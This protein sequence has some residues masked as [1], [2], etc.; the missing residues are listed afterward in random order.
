MQNDENKFVS[1]WAVVKSLLRSGRLL[2]VQQIS[3]HFAPYSKSYLR[4][5]P[6]EVATCFFIEYLLDLLPLLWP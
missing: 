5:I 6:L 4:E 1:P 3:P 2:R